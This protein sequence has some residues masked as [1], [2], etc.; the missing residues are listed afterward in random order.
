MMPSTQA[1]LISLMRKFGYTANHQG[2]CAGLICMMAF[3]ELVD[4]EERFDQ[5]IELINQLHAAK[6]TYEG[7]TDVREMLRLIRDKVKKH[8]KLTSFEKRMMGIDAFFAGIELAHHTER[9]RD[10]L[11]EFI[12]KADI[13][14]L[15]DV[16]G[17][18]KIAARGGVEKVYS[19]PF[20]GNEKK[21]KRYLNGL[22]EVLTEYE[23][24]AG[25][26]TNTRLSISLYSPL[27]RLRIKY[28]PAEEAWLFTDPNQLPTKKI[29]S[30]QLASEIISAFHDKTNSAFEVQVFTVAKNP[31]L[32]PVRAQFDQFRQ[33]RT[34]TKD[35]AEKATKKTAVQT[36]G[37]RIAHVAAMHGDVKTLRH[38]ADLNGKY[39]QV[40]DNDG[41]TPMLY[42]AQYGHEEAITFLAS[43]H[44][45]DLIKATALGFS[46]MDLIILNDHAHLIKPLAPYGTLWAGLPESESLI[47]KA[48]R[49][50]KLGV[51]VALLELDPPSVNRADSRGETPVHLLMRGEIE[52]SMIET[53]ARHGADFMKSS[54]QGVTPLS[55]AINRKKWDWVAIMLLNQPPAIEIPKSMDAAALR[56]AALTYLQSLPDADRELFI[57][58][59]K[60][61]SNGFGQW[62]F[63]QS[64]ALKAPSLRLFKEE[65]TPFAE[66]AGELDKRFPAGGGLTL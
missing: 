31:C 43:Q 45:S 8:N 28:L 14:Q 12:A 3:A 64:A 27:H 5:R 17:S 50:V 36:G 37:T 57:Q 55:L 23:K 30:R 63:N 61:K 48:A 52:A 58:G 15:S 34:I 21:L 25:D 13:E 1:P 60:T 47:F 66:F 33:F 56:E 7:T 51:L 39:L 54:A 2:I 46:P 53:L 16:I 65:A 11:G 18:K 44:R 26:K 6:I 20:I 41:Y 49:Q 19:E 38:L 22:S 10:F 24:N 29:P 9:Y 40:E 62:L 35:D 42:A 4:E 59:I 32:K